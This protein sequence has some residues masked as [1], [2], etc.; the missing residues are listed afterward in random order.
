M[1]WLKRGSAPFLS[2]PSH[3]SIE[4]PEKLMIGYNCYINLATVSNPFAPGDNQNTLDEQNGGN[5][6]IILPKKQRFAVASRYNQICWWNR[7][8]GA[9]RLY[10]YVNQHNQC[11]LQ[12]R[13]PYS[14]QECNPSF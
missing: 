7:E 8:R 6:P 13:I 14:Y 10:V 4:E 9:M 3:T 11:P 2:T 1:V 12:Q 5:S